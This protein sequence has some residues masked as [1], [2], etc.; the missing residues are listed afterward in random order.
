[1]E[2]FG[3]G[4]VVGFGLSRFELGKVLGSGS[5]VFFGEG[6]SGVVGWTWSAPWGPR[7]TAS[8]K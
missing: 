3:L 5:R 1:M 8:P 4:R 7:T 6:G 2:R